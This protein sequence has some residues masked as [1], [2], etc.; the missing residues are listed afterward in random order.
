MS[1]GF[2]GM[3]NEAFPAGRRPLGKPLICLSVR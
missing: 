3:G 2:R 1:R